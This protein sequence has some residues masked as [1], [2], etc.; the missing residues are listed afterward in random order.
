MMPAIEVRMLVDT[1]EGVLHVNFFTSLKND[2]DDNDFLYE[3]DCKLQKVFDSNND[4]ANSGHAII[5]H[6]GSELFT[7]FFD[8]DKDGVSWIKNIMMNQDDPTIH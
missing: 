6:M 4:I 7:V 2:L 3:L 1:D 5:S 8:R